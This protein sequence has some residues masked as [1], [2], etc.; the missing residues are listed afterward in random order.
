MNTKVCIL[1]AS[2]ILTVFYSIP[3][4]A[5]DEPADLILY[6]GKVITVNSRDLIAE[7]IAVKDGKITKVGSNREIKPLAGPTRNR[8]LPSPAQ[9]STAQS[10]S[11]RDSSCL[12]SPHLTLPCFGR[13]YPV[14]PLRSL[15]ALMA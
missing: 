2:I 5:F 8:R 14:A 4:Q 9:A 10:S 6:N 11:T 12:A 3:L 1:S 13:V 7:A 15:C